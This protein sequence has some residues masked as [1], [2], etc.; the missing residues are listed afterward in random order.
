M[1]RGM[2][3]V[4]LAAQIKTWGMELGFQAVGIAGVEL[5]QVLI[6]AASCTLSMPRI[7][8]GGAVNDTLLTG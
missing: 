8:T 3:K 4:Q 2:D 7:I 1:M 6:C 5:P